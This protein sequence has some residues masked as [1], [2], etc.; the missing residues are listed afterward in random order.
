MKMYKEWEDIQFNFVEYKDTG[1]KI[2][3]AVEDVQVCSFKSLIFLLYLSIKSNYL[4]CNNFTE[5]L[6]R[7]MEFCWREYGMLIQPGNS[8]QSDDLID[9]HEII[10]HITNL[11][12]V[13]IVFVK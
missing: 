7:K 10:S 6:S 2:L 8:L 3:S 12:F 1:V 11:L 13:F 4:Y 9:M 5:L